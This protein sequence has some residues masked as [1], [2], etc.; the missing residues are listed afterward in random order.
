V[1][2]HEQPLFMLQ[3]MAL[4]YQA[5][6]AHASMSLGWSL[7]CALSFMPPANGSHPYY[8]TLLYRT[9]ARPDYF[10]RLAG[11]LLARLSSQA[12]IVILDRPASDPSVRPLFPPSSGFSHACGLEVL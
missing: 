5:E 2:D 7:A 3:C 11:V 1:I 8:T 6:N 9:A 12:L 10:F 4:V